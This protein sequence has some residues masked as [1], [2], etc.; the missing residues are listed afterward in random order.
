MIVPGKIPTIPFGANGIQFS[1]ATFFEPTKT[2]EMIIDKLTKTII[3]ATLVDSFTPLIKRIVRTKTI[4]IA[5][6][7]IAIGISI[8]NG[9]CKNGILS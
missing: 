8:P 3:P 7:L 9:K 4:K 2:N 6:I 5:G 1:G